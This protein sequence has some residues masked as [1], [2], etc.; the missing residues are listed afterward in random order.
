MSGGLVP[1]RTIPP[2]S[3]VFAIILVLFE[4]AL[5]G[6]LIKNRWH[7]VRSGHIAT[8]SHLFENGGHSLP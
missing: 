8:S 7:I 3:V 1:P 4:E 2:L 5:F 6:D